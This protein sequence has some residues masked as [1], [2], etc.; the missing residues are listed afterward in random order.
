VQKSIKVFQVFLALK[1][2]LKIKRDRM[3]L[4]SNLFS[5]ILIPEAVYREISRKH[6]IVLPAFMEVVSVQENATLNLLK[7]LLDEGESEA[8][9]LA[10]ERKSKL[11]I[12]EKKGRKIALAQGLEIIGLLGIVY[13]NIRNG[14]LSRNEA[15]QF[16]DEALHHGYRINSKLIETM[17]AS[18]EGRQ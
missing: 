14:F 3:E 8:I 9:A 4:L 15:K 13:L 6:D 5:K 11:I 10:L 18:I 12:D 17:F 2:S 1:K 16:L 7:Q